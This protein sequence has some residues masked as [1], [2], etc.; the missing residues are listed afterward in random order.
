MEVSKLWT[1]LPFDDLTLQFG[2]GIRDKMWSIIW[3][4]SRPEHQHKGASDNINC[5]ISIFIT[6]TQCCTM[7]TF[8]PCSQILYIYTLNTWLRKKEGFMTN[9][10]LQRGDSPFLHGLYYY[11]LW[12]VSD[13]HTT[14]IDLGCNTEVIL[15]SIIW[16]LSIVELQSVQWGG[17]ATIYKHDENW[18]SLFSSWR[19][20]V[21]C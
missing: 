6:I 11:A 9:M 21:H 20:R 18:I 19:S 13:L 2:Q 14:A 15:D 8:F 1:L 3:D 16:F 4:K 17:E 10:M 12:L 7:C 5:K